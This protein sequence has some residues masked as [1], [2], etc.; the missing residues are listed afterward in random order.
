MQYI[1]DMV[2]ENPGE[3]PCPTAFRDP[4]NLARYQYNGLGISIEDIRTTLLSAK[5]D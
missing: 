1:L 2:H 4:E 3:A 5:H